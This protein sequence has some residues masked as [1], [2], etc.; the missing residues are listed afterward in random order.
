MLYLYGYACTGPLYS[1]GARAQIGAWH[2]YLVWAGGEVEYNGLNG[3]PAICG[4][5]ARVRA[6]QGLVMCEREVRTDA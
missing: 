4:R 2:F 5:F 1:I 3:L 6:T